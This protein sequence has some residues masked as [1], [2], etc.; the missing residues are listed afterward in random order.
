MKGGKLTREYFDLVKDVL[1]EEKSKGEAPTR[2]VKRRKTHERETITIES[3]SSE[4]QNNVMG[5]GTTGIRSDDNTTD[6]YF[7]EENED[8][9]NSEDFEDVTYDDPNNK[10]LITIDQGSSSHGKTGSNTKKS[11]KR[12]LDPVVKQYRKTC[13]IFILVCLFCHS[14][15][16]NKWCNDEKLQ[17]KLCKLVPDDIFEN[18]HPKK[19]DEMPLRSTRKLLD[20]LR[21][22]MKI[23]NTKFKQ[24]LS[25][26][27]EFT[28]LY[29]IPWDSQVV[30][31][32]VPVNRKVFRK[33]IGRLSGPLN[34]SVQG[35]VTMLRG[36]GL[37]AR[38]VHS[39]QP[40]DFTD[41][42]SYPKRITWKLEN[43]CLRFPI[44]WCEVWDK[45][46]KQWIT[47]DIAGQHI[48]EQVR[49][50][51]KL[52]PK[53]KTS[54]Y[55]NMMRYVIAYDRKLGCKDVSRRYISNLQNKI[56]KKRITKEPKFEGWYEK[57]LST[58]NQRKRNKID[59]YEED[60]FETRDKNEGIP[61]SLE[62]MKNHPLYVLEGHL[63]VNQVL[64]NDAKQCGF[65]RLRNKKNSILK[66][67]NRKDVIDCYSARHWYMQGRIL[68]TGARALLTM[69]VKD[70]NQEEDEERL[71]SFTETEYFIPNQVD[72][73][74]NIPTNVYGNIDV[75]KPWMIPIGC[76]LIEG[77]T[78]IRA[79][80]FLGIPFAKAV[81]GFKFERGRR[82]KPSVTGVVVEV[83]YTDAICLLMTDIEQSIEDDKLNDLEL[84]A[85]NSW[86]LL[87]KKLRIK[88]KLVDRH[89]A[90][91]DSNLGYRPTSETHRQNEATDIIEENSDAESLYSEFEQ[92]GFL[93]DQTQ[94]LSAPLQELFED[95]E[96]VI[97]EGTGGF[98]PDRTCENLERN[99]VMSESIK[100]HSS[101]NYDVASTGNPSSV[102]NTPTSANFQ[103]EYEDFLK[104][105]DDEAEIHE[106][107]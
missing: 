97:P 27:Y 17:K 91:A 105:F 65:L 87:L 86:S 43:D 2:P 74:G 85:I 42:K 82:A 46:S 100:E 14:F 25:S 54:S 3:D 10:L 9:Y 18:L 7:N 58:L 36:C 6:E 52:E 66:V 30:S 8:D 31:K 101:E 57:V 79:A 48:I 44:Y 47:V 83:E 59:G 61:D 33:L 26:P 62:D 22:C 80:K 55:C 24:E 99:N 49:N 19:D 12:T 88:S 98:I 104:E 106:T 93:P 15:I 94:A 69:K 32:S 50:K 34:V 38:L 23:W 78:A 39:V 81:T 60:Y 92:G 4:E 35:F 29:M 56:R 21:G 11:A 67:Y 16:R 102:Q 13:H 84:D 53:G 37:N 95:K 75:Y 64:Q 40:P 71:Y 51:S 72:S 63:K 103:D 70:K 76:C 28:H 68:K 45:F 5:S 77:L 41:H 89:G 96:P 20:A 1:L 73:G 107:I 90:I